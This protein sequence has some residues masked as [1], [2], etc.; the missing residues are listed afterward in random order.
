MLSLPSGPHG[1]RPASRRTDSAQRCDV[2]TVVAA[3][4]LRRSSMVL[5]RPQRAEDYSG[6]PEGR[7]TTA[8]LLLRCSQRITAS[9]LPQVA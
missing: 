7:T 3:V 9:Y 2:H 8:V 5:S 1:T 4:R 6:R